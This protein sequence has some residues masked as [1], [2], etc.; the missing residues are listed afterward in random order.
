MV[1][2]GCSTVAGVLNMWQ[3][4]VCGSTRAPKRHQFR[5]APALGD[6]APTETGM[7]AHAPGASAGVSRGLVSLVFDGRCTSVYFVRT[8]PG[9]M[10]VVGEGLGAVLDS[11]CVWDKCSNVR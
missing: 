11:V 1:T 3:Y 7:Y 4:K 8:G 2:A 6:G 5:E 9:D 10:I